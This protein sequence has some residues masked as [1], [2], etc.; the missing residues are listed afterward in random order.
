MIDKNQSVVNFLKQCPQLMEYPLFFNYINAKNDN[1]QMLTLAEEKALSVPYVDGSVLRKYTFT[2][3]VFKSA[4]TNPI[5]KIDGYPDENI[6]DML[7]VQGILDWVEEQDENRNYPNF[8]EDCAIDKMQALTSSPT[9]DGI[10]NDVMPALI[11]YSIS[12][13]IEYIDKSKMI[14]KK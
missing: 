10:N 5:V 1:V 12:I 2:L 13:E 9:L 8:G 3:I 4:I 11:Q 7:D 14:W 6:E